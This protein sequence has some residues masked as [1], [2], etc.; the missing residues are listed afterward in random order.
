MVAV[1]RQ[2]DTVLDRD[3]DKA[4]RFHHEIGD[5]SD[6]LTVMES[7]VSPAM[8]D[9]ID[10]CRFQASEYLAKRGFPPGGH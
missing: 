7:L 10:T 1:K 3:K 4:A 5:G 2:I 8:Q 9:M 6:S